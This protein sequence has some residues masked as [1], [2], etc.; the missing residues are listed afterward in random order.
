M[1]RAITADSQNATAS[2]TAVK[3]SMA[4]NTRRS[5]PEVPGA[6]R[7]EL[8][9]DEPPVGAGG[10]DE[11]L[12]V[13]GCHDRRDTAPPARACAMPRR[14]A[15]PAA[16]EPTVGARVSCSK[17]RRAP[18]QP[19][20]VEVAVERVRVGKLDGECLAVDEIP[21]SPATRRECANW[22]NRCR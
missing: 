13:S 22:S 1:G 15:R 12:R 21:A 17:E 7:L 8:I 18:L 20:V 4:I 2:D 3:A 14:P 16:G 6:T 19:D 5:L 11:Q 9:G 10:I